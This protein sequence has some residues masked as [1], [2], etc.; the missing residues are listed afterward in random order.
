MRPSFSARLATAACLLAAALGFAGCSGATG[1]S[2]VGFVS[3]DGSLTRIQPA[4]RPQA[5]LLTGKTLEG[6]DYDSA[7]AQG[8]VLVI[9][10]WGSWCAPCRKEA[11][12]LEA[13]AQ[14]TLGTAEFLG[15]NTRDLDPAPA[16]AFQRAFGVTYPSLYD[17]QGALLLKLAGLLSPNA[18]P[19]TL[20]IDR[21]GR[22]AARVLGATT[23][24]TIA[25]LVTDVAAGR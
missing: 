22:L 3:G 23:R 19:T 2:G 8:R 7:A 9:N 11:S 12:E 1:S 10:V 17:P 6:D 15:I 4:E 24:D 5:P 18:V 13:A 14:A 21:D 25:G 16:L 20:V